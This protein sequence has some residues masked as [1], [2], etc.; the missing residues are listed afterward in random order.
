[1]VCPHLVAWEGVE[2]NTP[3]GVTPPVCVK[4]C[5]IPKE[6]IVLGGFPTYVGGKQVGAPTVPSAVI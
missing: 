6:K 5:R 2:E 3:K 4:Y 1:M